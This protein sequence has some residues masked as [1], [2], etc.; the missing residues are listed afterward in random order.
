MCMTSGQ[1]PP[2]GLHMHGDELHGDEHG[3]HTHCQPGC[4]PHA[5]SRS[6]REPCPGSCV[7]GDVRLC[8]RAER[9]SSCP[10]PAPCRLGAPTPRAPHH[11]AA[12]S[13]PTMAAPADVQGDEE[14]TGTDA[15]SQARDS[16][17]RL[18]GKGYL[19]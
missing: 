17:C 14:R 12:G 1:R 9:L 10:P 11:S 4:K 16:P 15:A 19:P 3:L 2:G 6:V 13:N 7:M 5:C 18:G 8:W